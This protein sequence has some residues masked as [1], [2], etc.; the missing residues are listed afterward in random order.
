MKFIYK[1]RITHFLALTILLV[2]TQCTDLEEQV[3]D[4]VLGGESLTAES[5]LAA[6]YDRLG[7]KLFV[8]N[9]GMIAMQEYSTDE[10]L[11]PTRGSDW[12]DGGKWRAM[13]EFTWT[14]N[15]P[16]IVDNWNRLTNG[17]TRSLTAVAAI[18]ENDDAQKTLFLAE[19]KG[20]LAFYVYLT[21]DLY[22]QA[23]YRDPLDNSAALEA[24]QAA[25][26]I[27]ELINDVESIIPDLASLGQQSTHTGRFTKEAAYA[28]LADM[29]LN[30]A[31]FKDRFNPSSSFDFNET[32]LDGSKTDMDKVIEY[33]SMLIDNGS[34]SLASNYFSNFNIDNSGAPEHIFAVV[35]MIDNIRNGDNDLGYVNQARNQRPSPGNRGTNASCTTP[36][37]F[38]SWD[39]NHEDPRFSRKY[40]YA[41]GT[42]F[43][44]DGTTGSVP[45][46][47]KVPGTDLPWFHFNRGLLYGQQYGP[48]LDGEGGF[49]MTD[50]GRIKVSLL[51]ME[52]SS[53]TPMD[54][55]P[56][57]DFDN[58][59]ESVFKQN[60]INRGVRI[61]KYEF[62]PENGNGAS[63]F[64]IPIYRLGGIY[65]MRAE[66]YFRKGET[67]KAMADINMLRTS[68]TREGLYGNVSG[69][70]IASLDEETLYKEIGYELYWEMHRRPQMIRF[71]T[72]DKAYTAKP[73]T[74]PFR[75][76]FPIPQETIDV[77]DAFT[78]NS[79][80]VN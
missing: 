27:D 39:G 1:N 70:A 11:L 60:Q 72:F 37:F 16:A 29:Y 67:G 9:G 46:D 42:W 3:L 36:D 23:P 59:S 6:A 14:P 56:E 73:A 58:P 12:G 4:E 10:A 44:N 17:I 21:L 69:T 7:D 50:E 8:D 32:S 48:V 63:K 61:F 40:Q 75:R 5:T 28:L 54:F 55:T 52:K 79:G 38:A 65:T 64:D 19:A 71:G 74:D 15:T 49:I 47:D 26:T 53:D 35:Q 76:A 24:K 18:S 51:Y 77:S 34:F 2:F 31:V 25:A 80:Y 45:A 13:H 66:A 22:N 20:L 68:R 41:D 30:R 43:M 57:L 78:Q 62:D 33:T